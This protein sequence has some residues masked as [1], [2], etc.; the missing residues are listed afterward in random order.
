MT[1]HNQTKKL[2][3]WFLN[4]T[5]KTGCRTIT[6]WEGMNQYK[7]IVFILKIDLA[8]SCFSR[9][10]SQVYDDEMST[11]INR[12]SFGRATEGRWCRVLCGGCPEVGGWGR[13][14][15]GSET[16]RRAGRRGIYQRRIG[17][18]QTMMEAMGCVTPDDRVAR[19]GNPYIKLWNI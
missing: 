1:H 11:Y 16:V 13:Q 6:P 17:R 10:L 12:N 2:T 15:T 8:S 18:R 9:S 19:Y 14:R 5:A 3:T 4:N 7:I